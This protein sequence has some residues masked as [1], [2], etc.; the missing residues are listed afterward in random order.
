[1]AEQNRKTAEQREL[2]ERAEAM[3][4]KFVAY[5]QGVDTID[6]IAHQGRSIMGMWADFK[7]KSP[8]GSGYSGFCLLAEKVDRL[9]A[10]RM[11]A[12]FCFA[13]DKI[14]RIAERSPKRVEALLVDRL[15]RG[16]TKVAIDPFTQERHEIY[17]SDEAC[18]QLLGCSRKVFQRRVSEGY[19]QVERVISPSLAAAA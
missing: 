12:D 1:M 3:V 17:W 11:P 10:V 7:G 2:R 15:Y 16:R 5:L 19:A 9:R 14:S 6:Q 4:D 8:S 13:Y 18:C